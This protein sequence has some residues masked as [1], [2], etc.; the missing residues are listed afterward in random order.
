MY[1]GD[2]GYRD[3][4]IK[5]V[6]PSGQ[7]NEFERMCQQVRSRHETINGRIKNFKIVSTR[8]RN[9]RSKHW[10]CFHCITNMIQLEIENSRPTNSVFYDDKPYIY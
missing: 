6:T 8:F 1:I 4:Y 10:M 5:A 9:E 2:G 7:I 3:S